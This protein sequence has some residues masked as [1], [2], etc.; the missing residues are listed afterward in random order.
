MRL[1]SSFFFASNSSA[2]RMPM[3]RSSAIFLICSGMLNGSVAGAGG[4]AGAA[5]A[6]CSTLCLSSQFH[7]SA[8]SFLILAAPPAAQAELGE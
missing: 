6:R 5:A 8:S 2:L 7:R 3:S 4:A 1:S